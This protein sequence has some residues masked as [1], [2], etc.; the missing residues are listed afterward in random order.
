M[1]MLH[2]GL[3]NG[4]GVETTLAPALRERILAQ[5]ADVPPLPV[6]RRT[7]RLVQYGLAASLAV[8]CLFLFLLNRNETF[9]SPPAASDV[10]RPPSPSAPLA[11]VTASN[12]GPPPNRIKL[13]HTTDKPRKTPAGSDPFTQPGMKTSSPVQQAGQQVIHPRPLDVSGLPHA[14]KTAIPRPA[15]QTNSDQ[16]PMKAHSLSSDLSNT[17]NVRSSASEAVGATNMGHAKNGASAAKGPP[18]SVPALASSASVLKPDMMA[19]PKPSPG[20]MVEPMAAPPPQAATQSPAVQS[21]APPPPPVMPKPPTEVYRIPTPITIPPTALYRAGGGLGGGG[22]GFGGSGLTGAKRAA[23]AFGIDRD[24]PNALDPWPDA[25]SPP[26]DITNAP[27][28]K[29]NKPTQTVDADWLVDNQGRVSDIH[30]AATVNAVADAAIRDAI[31]KNH[32][33]PAMKNGK[34]ISARMFHTFVVNP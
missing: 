12:Q 18:V 32:Y 15:V 17:R 28:S 22:G 25:P 26:S 23:Q 34:P 21:P 8:N 29:T 11:H 14:F 9:T 30:L 16:M 3:Q 4:D 10:A 1:Q 33:L 24:K 19:G 2:V 13:E 5:V 31:Q 27:L 7:P 20:G 6:P